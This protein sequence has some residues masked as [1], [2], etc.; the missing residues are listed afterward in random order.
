MVIIINIYILFLFNN[1]HKQFI[2][3]NKKNCH[4]I[5]LFSCGFISNGPMK[6]DKNTDIKTF[7]EIHKKTTNQKNFDFFLIALK[8]HIYYFIS[9]K[10]VV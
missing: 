5:Y 6:H 3:E 10:K 8:N 1:E 4:H 7:K 2:K 9:R